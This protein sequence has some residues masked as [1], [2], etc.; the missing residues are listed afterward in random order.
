[1]K[2]LLLA[3]LFACFTLA[4]TAQDIRVYYKGAKPTISDF[5]QEFVT[6]EQ[7]EEEFSENPVRAVRRAWEQRSAGLPLDEGVK[8]TVDERNGYVLYEYRYEDLI[9]RMEMCFWN[10][11]DGKHKLFAYNNLATT[12]NGKPTVT[13]T[14]GMTF[15][16]YNNATKKLSYCAPP[17]FE[18]D[19]SAIYTL[20]RK[21]KDIIVTKWDENGNKWE[22]TL[23]WN[24][25]KFN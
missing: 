16:R 2:K 9:I 11:A 7:C 19:F 18:V 22:R 20:P 23:K 15:M 6:D 1:M 17:G 3:M 12:R 4:L 10:E 8:L 24:G 14:C 5:V 21:G 25:R 13:E